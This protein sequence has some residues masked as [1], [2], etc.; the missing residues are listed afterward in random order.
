MAQ[1][2]IISSGDNIIYASLRVR[3]SQPRFVMSIHKLGRIIQRIV[4][5]MFVCSS[6][7]LI[8]LV[9]PRCMGSSE[10]QR[11]RYADR[12]DYLKWKWF[13]VCQLRGRLGGLFG[14]FHAGKEFHF[15]RVDLE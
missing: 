14:L 12:R 7:V 13:F 10:L 9:C 3:P 15:L 1:M 5:Y 4:V 8:I 6:H 11:G 2:A